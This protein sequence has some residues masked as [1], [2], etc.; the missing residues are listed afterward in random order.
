MKPGVAARISGADLPGHTITAR[1]A[2]TSDAID[3]KARTFRAELDIP[4]HDRRLV[5]GLY[6]QVGFELKDTGMSQVPAATLLFGAGGPKVAV[7]DQAGTL[8]FRAV[9][10]GRDD[11]D[12]VELSSGVSEGERLVLNISSQLSDGDRVRIG[13]GADAGSSLAMGVAAQ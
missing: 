8:R 11:G 13:N 6:V 1:I 10:I 3:P 9:S 7:V 12:S 4:N 2:R 5:P